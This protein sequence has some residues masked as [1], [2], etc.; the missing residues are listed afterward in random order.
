[1]VEIEKALVPEDLVFS[2]GTAVVIVDF[3]SRIRSF[4]S[5]ASFQTFGNAIRSVF[6]QVLLFV[7]ESVS[8]LSSTAIWIR[9]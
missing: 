4:P 6:Q 1:M 5:L 3:M 7:K 9:L 2:G 8:M